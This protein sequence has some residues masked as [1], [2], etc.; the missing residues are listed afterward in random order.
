MTEELPI[1]PLRTVLFPGLVLPLHIFEERYRLLVSELIARPDDV[2]RRLGIVAIRQGQE[3]GG[4]HPDLYE[5]G[6]AA[7]L[8]RVEP[9]DDGRFDIVTTGGSRFRLGSIDTSRPYLT[10]TVETLPEE[11]GDVDRAA[12]LAARVSVAFSAYLRA[13]ATAQR[14]VANPPRLSEDPLTLSYLVASGLVLDLPDRQQLLAAP[15]A[16]ARLRLAA[17]LLGR[18]TRLVRELSAPPALDLTGQSFSAN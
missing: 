9:Y 15:D 1:F 3:A 6:C 10:G 5:V 16:A 4:D 8:H 17:A 2:P 13:L 18:E 7:E 11:I 12:T 14:T